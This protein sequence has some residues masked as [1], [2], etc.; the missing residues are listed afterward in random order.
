MAIK[1][2]LDQIKSLSFAKKGTGHW[3]L[4]RM[5]SVLLLPLTY[6]MLKLFSLCLNAPYQQTVDWLSF[7]LNTLGIM[8]WII[9]VFYHTALGLQVVIEDY[10][11]EQRLQTLSIWASNLVFL[12]LSV[13]ALV[14]VFRIVSVG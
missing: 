6:F 3:W 8:A 12:L 5:T 14:A 11:A 7:P 4:E 1:I 10:V 9:I 2:T 13:T